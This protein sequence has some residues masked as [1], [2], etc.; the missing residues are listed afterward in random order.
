LG[1]RRV[2]PALLRNFVHGCNYNYNYKNLGHIL[3]QA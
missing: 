1:V 3:I 2:T